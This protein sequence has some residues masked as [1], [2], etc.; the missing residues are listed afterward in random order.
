MK[1]RKLNLLVCLVLVSFIC[2]A[3]NVFAEDKAIDPAAAKA[4]D[5]ATATKAVESA[6]A[7]ASSEISLTG[8]VEKTDAG[9]IIK[10]ADTNYMVSG[11]DL[12][13]L[14]GKTVK[15]TGTL[16]EGKDGKTINVLSYEE[17]KK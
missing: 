7:K 11:Q 12:A 3:G 5:P 6:V 2:M 16:S 8:A 9:M 13:T 4:M 15:V 17:I 1:I 10:V 14:V